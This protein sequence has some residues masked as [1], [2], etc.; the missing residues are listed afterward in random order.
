MYSKFIAIAIKLNVFLFLDK[1]PRSIYKPHCVLQ[2]ENNTDI[3]KLPYNII[4]HI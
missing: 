3:P 4:E 1:V 2:I